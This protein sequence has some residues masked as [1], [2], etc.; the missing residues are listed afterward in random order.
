MASKKVKSKIKIIYNVQIIIHIKNK[1]IIKDL[2]KCSNIFFYPT[3][4]NTAFG[5]KVM[6]DIFQNF[7]KNMH[8]QKQV[9]IRV[10]QRKEKYLKFTK[11]LK[12]N[13]IS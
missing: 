8:T 1:I 7:H 9:E 5:V 6:F 11:N 4:K 3:K 13:E 10:G 12:K 2:L